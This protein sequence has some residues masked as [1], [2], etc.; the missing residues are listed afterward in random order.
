MLHLRTQH[1]LDPGMRHLLQHTVPIRTDTWDGCLRPTCFLNSLH[2]STSTKIMSI[3]Y[4]GHN[5]YCTPAYTIFTLSLVANSVFMTDAPPPYPGIYGDAAA[6][7]NTATNGGGWSAP[8]GAGATPFPS[9]PTL[10]MNGSAADAK[11]AEAAAEGT[12]QTGYY[13]PRNPQTGYIPPGTVCFLYFVNVTS[14]SNL[15]CNRTETL[16]SVLT[17]LCIF[18]VNCLQAM[19]NRQRRTTRCWKT[20]KVDYKNFD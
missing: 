20:K 10:Q 7:N 16:T 19:M 13:D 12:V 9:A 3:V 11:A 17:I 1:L 6:V 14:K 2:V 5:T 18:R 4:L 8:Q 15:S